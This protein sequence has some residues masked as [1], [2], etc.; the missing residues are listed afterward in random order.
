MSIAPEDVPGKVFEELVDQYGET[1]DHHVRGFLTTQSLKKFMEFTPADD[2]HEIHASGHRTDKEETFT[3]T[4]MHG[5]D[6]LETRQVLAHKAE[7]HWDR[8]GRESLDTDGLNEFLDGPEAIDDLAINRVVVSF[9]STPLQNKLREVLGDG[10]GLKDKQYLQSPF[11]ATMESQTP[12]TERERTM[13]GDANDDE[14][15]KQ[16]GTRLLRLTSI[17]STRAMQGKKDP[18]FY[19]L[20]PRDLEDLAFNYLQGDTYGLLYSKLLTNKW[21]SVFHGGKDVTLYKLDAGDQWVPVE[22]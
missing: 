14:F 4:S 6:G 11:F 20:T 15:L 21:Q 13:I 1:Q 10:I 16:S 18:I 9:K 12:V 7:L 2:I 17:Y 5:V 19:S 22:S 8:K 3:T